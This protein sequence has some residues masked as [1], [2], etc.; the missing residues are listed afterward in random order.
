MVAL[1]AGLL[2]AT[3]QAIEEPNYTIL[4]TLNDIELRE[5]A[6]YTVAEVVVNADA[7]DAGSRAFPILAG[8]IFGKNKGERK[9]A[10]TAPVSQTA[11]PVKL[12]MTAP[13]TQTVTAGGYLVQFV[14]PKGVTLANAPEPL[15]AR[16]VLREVKPQ[17]MAVI[18]YTGFWSDSNF[19]EHLAKLQSG[20]RA[21]D[22]PWTG[23]P[24]YSR[25]DGP[26]TPW[27]LRR[28]EIWLQMA[29]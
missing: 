20:L 23:E 21:A 25:Y 2:P 4:R 11:V 17:R 28:N 9:M 10:M 6:G 8:Y 3:S 22:I 12:D 19:N 18:R 5:Y 1:A 15:D 16:V 27:F 7:N 24:V 14:L 26:T 13:V 29:P